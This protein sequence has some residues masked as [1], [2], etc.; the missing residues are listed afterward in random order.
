MRLFGETDGDTGP[1]EIGLDAVG[2][3]SDCSSLVLLIICKDLGVGVLGIL[4]T[5]GE[6]LDA[7]SNWLIWS[8]ALILKSG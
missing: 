7:L 3:A 2:Y 5:R 6:L 1:V 8:A 4:G